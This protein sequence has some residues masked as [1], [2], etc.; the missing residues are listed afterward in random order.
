MKQ[1]SLTVS[2]CCFVLLIIANSCKKEDQKPTNISAGYTVTTIAGTGARGHADG[3]AA[4]SQ[5][6][7]PH[8]IVSDAQGNIYVSDA[9]NYSIRKITKDGMV[10]TLAGGTRGTGDGNGANAQ[11]ILPGAL[12]VDVQGNIYVADSIRIRKITPS[13]NVT[14]VTGSLVSANPSSTVPGTVSNFLEG[15]AV[16][17]QGNIYTVITFW[18]KFQIC[19]ITPAGNVSTFID[20]TQNFPTTGYLSTL[21][22]IAI[23]ES[24]N[25]FASRNVF[26]GYEIYKISPSKTVTLVASTPDVS[27]IAVNPSSDEVFFTGSSYQ[28]SSLNSCKNL[29]QVFKLSSGGK[30]IL[31]AGN[32][33]GF[34]DG[35]GDVARFKG[36]GGISADAQCNLYVADQENNRVRKIS[37][38]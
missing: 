12:A 6:D 29:Y 26:A 37:K 25:I 27:G 11:F 8:N 17:K 30:S 38:R 28:C 35:S 18:L 9:S 15:I 32:D 4:N 16:D 21:H 7:R 5:F 13:G 3:P 36:V 24:G 34:V 31:V 20:S 2:I 23:D 33:E 14:S 1:T 22:H 10:S 19:K